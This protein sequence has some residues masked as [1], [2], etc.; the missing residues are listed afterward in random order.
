MARREDD[1]QR[2]IDLRHDAA[3][4]DKP[5]GELVRDM[6]SEL[7]NLFRKEV[8]L[9]KVETK[10]ELRRAARAGGMLGASGFT[11]YLAVL[12]LSFALAWLLDRWMPTEV[13]FLI[14]GAV[15]AIAASVLYLRGRAEMREVHPMPEETIETLKEDAEWLR[16]QRR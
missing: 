1:L 5:L 8:E 2:S 13:A 7:S 16:T 6:T 12:F 14:V 4:D 11:G 9:A 10:Q 3:R 15:Y